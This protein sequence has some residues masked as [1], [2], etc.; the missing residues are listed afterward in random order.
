[1]IGFDHAPVH[2][3]VKA[4]DGPATGGY[5]RSAADLPENNPYFID[6]DKQEDGA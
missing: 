4:Y 2:M 6:K 5:S 3:R 1:M